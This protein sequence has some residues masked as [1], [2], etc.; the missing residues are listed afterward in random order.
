MGGDAEEV[1]D[2]LLPKLQLRMPTT[3][4]G[5]HYETGPLVEVAG[6]IRSGSA[7]LVS[8]LRA[9]SGSCPTE[10]WVLIGQSEG[11]AIVHMSLASLPGQVAAVVLLADPIWVVASSYNF[12][13][14]RDHVAHRANLSGY[15]AI[16]RPLLGTGVGFDHIRDSVPP[17]MTD[18]VRSYC[19]REDSIACPVAP[20]AARLD[21]ARLAEYLSWSTR[22]LFVRPLLRTPRRLPAAVARRRI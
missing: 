12:P 11:A 17:G 21:C 6:H 18:R 3:A 5:F 2:H 10:Q 8:F 22:L 16:T 14:E 1:V 7:A 13:V 9:R 4:V 20:L 19:L 15:G